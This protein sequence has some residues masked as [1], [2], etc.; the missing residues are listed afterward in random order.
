MGT[1]IKSVRKIYLCRDVL[2]THCGRWKGFGTFLVYSC[3]DV[4]AEWIYY[5][6]TVEFWVDERPDKDFEQG[7][8]I[9]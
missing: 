1:L 2:M 7:H 8:M 3:G 6:T 4:F 9:I 5:C